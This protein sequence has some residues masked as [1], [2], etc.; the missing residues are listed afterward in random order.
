[1]LLVDGYSHCVDVLGN[2]QVSGQTVDPTTCNGTTAQ[3]WTF[4]ALPPPCGANG[5]PACAGNTCNTDLFASGSPETCC[6]VG[7]IAQ[8]GACVA[9]GENTEPVCV[10]NTCLGNPL[11]IV[12]G[13]CE[14]CGGTDQPCCNGTECNPNLSCSG[15]TPT[16]TPKSGGGSSSGGSSS[17]GS[18]GTAG[19]PG[20]ACLSDGTCSKGAICVDETT[21]YACGLNYGIC[22][23]ED[24]F[25][26]A[27]CGSGYS[28][29]YVPDDGSYMCIP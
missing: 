2:T 29:Q 24:R 1:M 19:K 18:S 17:G 9:C 26:A 28:C 3:V 8:K 23:N 22:C 16:C 7:F 13:K 20:Y 11:T 5:E 10:D 6:G 21:C 27:Q 4:Q 15:V 12:N 14:T 25:N